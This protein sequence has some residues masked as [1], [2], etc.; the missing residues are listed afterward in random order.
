MPISLKAVLFDLDGT[1]LD[2]AP[3]FH[4][5]VSMQLRKHGTAPIAFDNFRE[6]VSD[7]ARGMVHR[8][9]GIAP[10]DARFE[11][12]RR[13]FL[14]LYAQHL[15]AHTQLFPG[16]PETLA[17]IESNN[18][19]WGI[20]T[21]KPDAFSAPLIRALGLAERCATLICPDHVK[22]RKPDPESLLLACSQIDCAVSE[23]IYVGDH[24]RDIE[25]ARAA[26]MI[27]IACDYGY[28]HRDDPCANWGADFIVSRAD[29][30]VPILKKFIR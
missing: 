17:F 19:R 8:A 11:P 7:G 5:I 15:G 18:W 14:D 10:A 4:E 28:V 9:F 21:N 22:Q 12:L 25:C 20:V 23:A 6:V 16:M 26:G 27:S 1:L 29:D 2:T 3:E 13:E 24:R 30:I